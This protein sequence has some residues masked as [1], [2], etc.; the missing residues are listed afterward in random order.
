MEWVG[1]LADI[2]FIMAMTDSFNALL[3]DK[4]NKEAIRIIK[5][6]SAYMISIVNLPRKNYVF[7]ICSLIIL[8]RAHH[9]K[10]LKFCPKNT[11]FHMG[12]FGI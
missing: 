5:N 3:Y 11:N 8:N 12:N 6:I 9:L 1:G 4:S 7:D 10:S 2:F